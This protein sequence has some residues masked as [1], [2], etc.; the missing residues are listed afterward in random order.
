MFTFPNNPMFISPLSSSSVSLFRSLFL[1]IAGS[2][3]F[4]A[5][6]GCGGGNRLAS[7][8]VSR[9]AERTI[10]NV[11]RT[12]AHPDSLRRLSI[13][14]DADRMRFVLAD[15]YQRMHEAWSSKFQF[16][17]AQ[18]TP[19]DPLTYATLWSKELSLTALEAEERVSTLPKEKAKAR[20]KQAR[21][22]YR[23]A[24]QIDVYWFTGPDGSSITGP[25][26]RVRL[27]DGEGNSYEPSR[28][29]DSPLRDASIL[30]RNFLLYRRNIFHFQR[31]RDGRDILDGVDELRLRVNPTG[32]P[33]V[34][35]RWSWEG[36]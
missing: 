6:V 22:D 16:T 25:G 12:E 9:T 14:E 35:F 11:Q 30:G 34:E 21:E 29:E 26:A 4:G 13:V 36:R 27:V 33:E 18:R 32:G 5:T 19:S 24:L 15:S 20:I 8:D 7:P 28:E 1:V 10:P 17:G 3:L 23:K 31:Q 2:F